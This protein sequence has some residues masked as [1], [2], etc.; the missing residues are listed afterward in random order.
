MTQE[1]S[2]NYRRARIQ[3]AYL[4]PYIRPDSHIL[5]VGAG[6]GSITRD[7]AN[8][9]PQGR[10]VGVDCAIEMVLFAQKTHIAYA[11]N[12]NNGSECP[13]PH[14]LSFEVC[15]AEDLSKFPDGSFDIVHAHTCITHVKNRV[16]ALR[17]F[18]RVCK[19][20]GVVAVRDPLDIE[21]QVVWIPDL[22]AMRLHGR[23]AAK[24]LRAKGGHPEAGSHLADWA[25]EAGFTEDGGRITVGYGEEKQTNMLNIIGAGIG[26]EQA[27]NLGILTEEQLD[28]FNTAYEIWHGTEGH[29][30]IGK[31]AEMLCFK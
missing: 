28:D 1:S 14:N 30:C 27:I 2:F 3:A 16:A 7:F 11:S 17:E 12:D 23:I 21:K 26:K 10:V 4:L 29:I 20:G 9:C 25:R 13:R 8:L 24:L 15:N 31:V 18:R 22:P 5:D 19:V 6:S